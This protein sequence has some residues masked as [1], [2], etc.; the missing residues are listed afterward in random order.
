MNNDQREK[1][2]IVVYICFMDSCSHNSLSAEVFM[3]AKTTPL[4]PKKGKRKGKKNRRSWK[5]KS[6]KRGRGVASGKELYTS[7]K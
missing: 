6:P 5:P 7:A 2:V 3:L 4:L 1:K